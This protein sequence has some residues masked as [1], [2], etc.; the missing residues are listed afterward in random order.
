M[1][2]RVYHAQEKALTAPPDP[3]RPPSRPTAP[4]ASPTQG[5]SGPPAGSARNATAGIHGNRKI[6]VRSCTAA[7]RTLRPPHPPTEI[8][9]NP[10]AGTMGSGYQSMAR[11]R[12]YLASNHRSRYAFAM[13]PT[14]HR[15]QSP[16]AAGL[17]DPIQESDVVVQD[18]T[19]EL[20]DPGITGITCRERGRID[21]RS[22][23]QQVT[24]KRLVLAAGRERLPAV[25]ASFTGA[26]TIT[27]S[28]TAES[29]SPSFTT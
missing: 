7:N 23:S 17:R 20:P 28:A 2:R 27:T 8:R 25:G 26:T 22:R 14:R 9:A 16:K 10:Q 18:L 13:M 3:D 6:R 1:E 21:A 11:L 12:G 5:R 4:P 19:L 24:A 15:S 29:S